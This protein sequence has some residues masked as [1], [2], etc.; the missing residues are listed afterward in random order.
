MSFLKKKSEELTLRFSDRYYELLLEN[1]KDIDRKTFN[2]TR[3]DIIKFSG[4][5][6]SCFYNY[7]KNKIPDE[8]KY[9]ISCPSKNMTEYLK[10]Y[11]ERKKKSCK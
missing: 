1:G 8:D 10:K 9:N 7:Y 5:S 2:E 6:L 4:I 11:R 3:R